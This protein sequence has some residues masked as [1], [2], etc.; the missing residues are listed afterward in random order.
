MNYTQFKKQFQNNPIIRSRDVILTH[1]NPQV[2]RN[3][4]SRWH[5]KGLLISLRK[6]VYLL[7]T[8]DRKVEVDAHVLG[9]VLYEPSYVSLEYALYYYG[10]IPEA[11]ADI[12]S[13]TTRAT[14]AFTNE[15]GHFIY[16]HV[17]PGVFRGFKKFEQG[18]MSYFMAEPEK[19]LVDF[20]Y[21]NLSKFKDD[22]RD[23][24]EHSYRLQNIEDLNTDRF[25]EWAKLFKT[26][27]LMRV[28]KN[29]VVW[30]KKLKGGRM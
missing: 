12:T 3:Q 1:D 10:L 27:K 28:I 23:I 25:I 24:L 9:N 18:E 14:A 6:G 20:L 16:Q 26:K 13:V 8:Q 21:L 7:N 22:P 29:L 2:L 30:I 15:M 19:A 5:K 17:K 4:L 11:V